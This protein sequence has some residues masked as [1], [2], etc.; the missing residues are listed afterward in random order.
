MEG[1]TY[2]GKGQEKIAT[3]KGMLGEEWNGMSNEKINHSCVSIRRP[4]E[5]V[6]DN[7]GNR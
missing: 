2:R 5:P 7:A 6:H 4:L 1:P 3:I